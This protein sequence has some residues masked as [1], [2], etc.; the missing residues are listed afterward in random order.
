[1]ASITPLNEDSRLADLWPAE[2]GVPL[3]LDATRPIAGVITLSS[4]AGVGAGMTTIDISV[5]G[6][7]A[8]GQSFVLGETSVSYTAVPL[9]VYSTAWTI[10]P[11]AAQDKKDFTGITL[12]TTVR[13]YNAMH[14]FT[15]PSQSH[16]TMGTWT[17]SFTPR[18]ELALNN[19]NFSATG[20]TLSED[21][22]SWTAQVNTPPIGSHLLKA[23]AVQGA[24]VSVVDTRAFSV[25]A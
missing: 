24:D 4:Y 15:I 6:T 20:V 12:S 3:T 22:A 8:N 11:D 23:R 2:S 13:G 9:R 5:T 1:M 14:G 10:Q 25:T 17:T 18:V 19:G 21:K 7:L 16:F